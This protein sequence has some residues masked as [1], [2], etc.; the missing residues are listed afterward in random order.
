MAPAAAASGGGGAAD[1][2]FST[3]LVLSGFSGMGA[4][5]VCHPLDVIRSV[6]CRACSLASSQEPA[7]RHPLA[8][9]SYCAS[10]SRG[11][12]AGPVVGLV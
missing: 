9:R 10:M 7:S 3:R 6:C 8:L 12:A 4:A 11:A 5:T 2:A 1:V